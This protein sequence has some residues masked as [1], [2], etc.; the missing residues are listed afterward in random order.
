MDANRKSSVPITIYLDGEQKSKLDQLIQHFTRPGA[1]SGIS[2]V[3]RYAIEQLYSNV[4]HLE[5][6]EE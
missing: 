1:R 4:F 5:K 2:Y 3:I 6:E